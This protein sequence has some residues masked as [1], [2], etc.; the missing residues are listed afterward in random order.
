MCE[1]TANTMWQSIR[2][3][4]ALTI[5][6]ARSIA[7]GLAPPFVGQQAYRLCRQYVEDII[8]VPELSICRAVNQLYQ[9]GSVDTH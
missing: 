1:R 3:G 5:K 9:Q 4:E 7:S 6:T 2:A 8:V